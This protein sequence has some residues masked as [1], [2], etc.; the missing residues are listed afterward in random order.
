MRKLVRILQAYFYLQ[1][2]FDTVHKDEEGENLDDDLH[3][4]YDM[5]EHEENYI[6]VM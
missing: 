5:E 3:D 2:T 6:Q 4:E 1:I